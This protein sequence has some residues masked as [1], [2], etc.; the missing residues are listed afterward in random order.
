MNA[1]KILP[2]IAALS[3]VFAACS[4]SGGSAAGSDGSG[5]SGGSGTA[6]TTA[7]TVGTTISF[8][9]TTDTSVTVTWGAATDGVTAQNQLQYRLLRSISN[10]LTSVSNAETNGTEVLAY[11]TN[12]L[13]QS[14]SGLT[15]NTQYYFAVVVKDAAGNK[16]LYTQQPVTTQAAGSV[17]APTFSPVA[18]TYTSAQNVTITSATSG[19]TVCYRTDGTDP[20][21]PTQGTCGGGSTT[22][23]GAVNIASTATLKALATKSG[24]ANSGVT[25]GIYT[26]D[27]APTAGT[28]IS[29][30]SVTA[31][32]LTVNWGAA[33]DAITA[34]GSLEYKL[35][36]DNTAATGIDTIA[37]ADA[38]MGGDLLLDWTA[39]T[40]TKAVTGL[41]SATSYHFAV[42]VRD[43]AG[44]K[45]LYTPATQATLTNVYPRYHFDTTGKSVYVV[46]TTNA[47]NPSKTNG[48]SVAAAF[49]VFADPDRRFKAAIPSGAAVRFVFY[50][51]NDTLANAFGRTTEANGYQ[52]SWTEGDVYSTH[53]NTQVYV[54][55]NYDTTGKSVYAIYTTN[56][57]N[58][59]KTNGTSVAGTF[60]VYD[61]ATW[62]RFRANIP[63]GANTRYIFYISNDTLA[64]GYGRTSSDGYQTTWTE[65]DSTLTLPQ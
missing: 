39:N 17:S 12:Q 56:G 53:T 15:Q 40:L 4:K 62:R 10:N 43:A 57:T 18:G 63:S 26:I 51:S 6:D 65:G 32:E 11:T 23:S 7:P 49:D 3:L 54:Y 38:K 41:T 29:F 50:V 42:L 27:L 45:T 16:A 52:T 20:T 21:A 28:A 46:Y 59:S 36:K 31:T 64:N 60:D 55:Y 25:S 44:N 8:S 19:A 35:V 33:T 47:T 34:Q 2:L 9:G 5:S 58:P 30:A 24:S 22:Y 13:S 14:A 1:V 37:E 48:T 61:G